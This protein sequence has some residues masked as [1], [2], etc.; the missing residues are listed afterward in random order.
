MSP[1]PT[2]RVQPCNAAPVRADGDFVL[3]WMIAF[4]RTRWNFSLQHAVEWAEELKKPLVIF[5]PLRVGYPWASDRLHRFVLDG[6]ADRSRLLKPLHSRGVLYYPYVEPAADEGNGLLAEL[7][8]RACVVVTDEYPSFFLPRMVRSAARQ[9]SV[10]LEQVDANGLLPLRAAD[11]VFSTA[12]SFRA[13]LQKQLPAH[14]DAL[15]RPD[16]LARARLPGLRSLPA[17]VRRRWPPAAARLLAGEPRELARLPLDHGVRPVAYRGGP[18]AGSAALR[19]FLDQGLPR[20]A[21]EANHPDA[22]CRS[23]LSPYLHFGH[24]SAHEIFAE[25]ARAEDWSPAM[26]APGAGGKREGWWGMNPPAEAFLDELV[27]WRELG[28]NMC[29]LRDDYDHFESLPE[30][31]RATLTRHAADRRPFVYSLDDFEAGRTHDPLWN[32][33][34]AQLVR[35]GRIHNYLRMLWGKKIL[36]WTAGPRDALRVMI[37]LNNKY[38]V[39]GRDPNSYSGIFWVLGRYDR[40]WGPERPVFGTVRYMSSPSTLRKL[41][42]QDYLARYGAASESLS[43]PGTKAAE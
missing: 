42:V 33:A 16:P 1:V 4:R 41:R 36:E 25:V 11:R 8:G 30:W 20:Y 17:I 22:D 37:E 43:P 2:V 6:M 29:F 31:A 14:L 19:R 5:E 23:G 12:R 21:A 34:Q 3:Y 7:A 18:T 13:F 39:D 26:L 24:L 35:E 9:L 40:P 32:A 38:G 10:R 15:P 27:T 28:F